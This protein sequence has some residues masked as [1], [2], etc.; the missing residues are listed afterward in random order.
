MK[1]LG[2]LSTLALTIG[3]CSGCNLFKFFNKKVNVYRE[4]DVV[5]KQISLRFY[6]DQR[7]VPYIK[8]NSYFNEFFSKE[9][10]INKDENGY[11]YFVSD[12]EYLYFNLKD[13]DITVLGLTALSDHP[14]FISNNG[15]LFLRAESVETSEAHPKTI[16]LDKYNIHFY[17]EDNEVY[18]PLSFLSKLCGG[19]NLYNVA[20]NG[21]DVYVLD[22]GANLNGEE[23]TADYF[24]D[25]YDKKF[26]NL[27]FRS[28]DMAEYSYNELCFVFDNFKGETTQM[29]FK[30]DEFKSLGL[31]K[32][33]STYYPEI[34]DCL[35]STGRRKFGAGIL[36][37]FFGLDDGGHTALLSYYPFLLASLFTKVTGSESLSEL[38]HYVVD[39]ENEYFKVYDSCNLYRNT[40]L[41]TPN[42]KYYYI[43]Q[44]L[45]TAYIG[46]DSFDV[47]YVGWDKYYKGEGSI[48]VE[49]D[50]Y[51]FVRDKLYKAIN[52]GAKKI[53]FDLSTNSGGDSNAMC[54]I[55]GLLNK[56][57]SD[58][59]IKDTFN[60]YYSTDNYLVDINLDGEF[61]ELDTLE[62]E[63]FDFKIGVLTS[64]CSFSCANLFAY[65]MKELG[66]MS[67]GQ[68]SGGGSC[69]I[70]IETT[71]EGLAYS[72]SSHLTLFDKDGGNLDDGV[73]VDYEIELV[74]SEYID[75]YDASNF[76]SCALMSEYLDNFYQN[77]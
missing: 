11:K 14:D 36:S 47:D 6:F 18:A 53:I 34:K 64:K 39:R 43:E 54:G 69:A 8:V 46:F 57:K 68:R 1:K 15:K 21:K 62:C 25:K 58:F 52:A 70:S 51:A 74:D 22:Y 7:H 61:N 49:T 44:D 55:I 37:L 40:S 75:Y 60:D 66:F 73:P 28:K 23:R 26:S 29:V 32:Y 30:N 56:A 33:L 63:K 9:L 24:E 19:I 17:D 41:G 45:E 5:D 31:D 27:F 4:K 3:I 67:V 20:Y 10:N 16:D 65:L 38:Y 50:T 71:A 72:R 76:Y 77:N 59:T 42:S 48:P 2:L 35:L 13:N 12:E